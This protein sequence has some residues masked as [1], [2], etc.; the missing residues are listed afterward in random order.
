MF[1]KRSGCR[2]FADEKSKQLC[3]CVCVWHADLCE[4]I[5]VKQQIVEIMETIKDKQQKLIGCNLNQRRRSSARRYLVVC[6]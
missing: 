4:D 3:V 6:F 2:S 1:L 5:E